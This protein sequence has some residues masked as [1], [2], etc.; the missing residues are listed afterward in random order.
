LDQLLPPCWNGDDG[1]SETR[2]P[3]AGPPSIVVK[4]VLGVEGWS[5]ASDAGSPTAPSTACMSPLCTA[6]W[7][8][9]TLAAAEVTLI[10]VELLYSHRG[11]AVAAMTGRENGWILP[12]R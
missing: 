7:A 10:L 6:T 4:Y 1:S 9:T 5:A 3:L 8:A 2:S 12:G 11:R